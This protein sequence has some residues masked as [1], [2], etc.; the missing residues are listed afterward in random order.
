MQRATSNALP[1]GQLVQDLLMKIE[2]AQLVSEDKLFEAW[3]E[4]AGE[5]GAKN[6]K[7]YSL[8]KGVLNVTVKNSSWSQ[9]LTL[10]KRWV[11][12]KLQTILG[13]ELIHD[14]RFRTGQL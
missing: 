6:S 5:A 1:V 8:N 12:K 10:Q 4:A 9:E 3:L 14:I 13:K 7:P 2:A 11:L